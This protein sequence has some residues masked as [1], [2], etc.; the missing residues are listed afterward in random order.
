MPIRHSA[1]DAADARAAQHL[2]EVIHDLVLGRR[3]AGLAQ[4]T[5]ARAV[6]VSRSA[7]ASWEQRR[8]E[9]TL[10]QL[11]RW[12]A[13]VGLDVSLR[14]FPAGEPLR[15]IGQLR[16]LDRF[17]RLVGGDWQW[18]TEVPIS[19]DP[20]ERRAF[21]A[22]I[23]RAAARAAVEAVSRL[24]D[25]QGQLRPIMAKQAASGMECV[26]LVLADTRWNRVAAAAGEA[27][28]RPAFPVPPRPALGALRTGSVPEANAV[29]FA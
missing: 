23:R 9:P 18:Q 17:R 16:L 14:T 22:V 20:R 8:V 11:S 12:G 24:V 26:L 2:D 13:A 19:A 27:T 4:A 3:Q 28:L 15:D 29:I 6:G 21:D 1:F 7:V 10:G 5:I 25:V